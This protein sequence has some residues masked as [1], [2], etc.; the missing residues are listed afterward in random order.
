M[1]T[2]SSGIGVSALIAL[3]LLILLRRCP[4]YEFLFQGWPRSLMCVSTSV[5]FCRPLSFDV[6][7]EWG[8]CEDCQNS[9]LHARLLWGM[10]TQAVLIHFSAEKAVS[11]NTDLL[12]HRYRYLARTSM[13][14]GWEDWQ[15]LTLS[16]SLELTRRSTTFQGTLYNSISIYSDWIWLACKCTCIHEGNR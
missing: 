15:S 9:S 6:Q 10:F 16:D 14:C 5:W 8:Q 4:Y 11:F 7:D 3:Y 2:L 12:L 1:K 13:W